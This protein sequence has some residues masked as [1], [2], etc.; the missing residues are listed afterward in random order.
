MKIFHQLTVVTALACCCC[1]ESITRGPYLQLSTPTSIVIRWRTDAVADSCVAYGTNATLLDL[2]NQNATLVTDHELT[3]TNLLPDTVYYYSAGSTSGAVAGTGT[4]F[5]FTTHPPPGAPQPIRVWVIGDAGTG[6]ANQIAVRDAFAAFNGTNRIHAWLQLGDNAYNSGTDAEYQANMFNLYSNLL[7]NTVTW[8]ALG[9][10]DTAQLTDFGG[11]YPYFDIFTLP[12]AGE[13]GGAASGTEHYYSFDVGMTHFICLDSMTASRATNGAMAAWLRTDL[14]ANTNRWTIAYWH[15]PPYSK[16]THDSDNI[17]EPEMV[18]MRQN[19]NP[20]LEAGGV[21]LV[22]SGHSHSYER[23]YLI[24]GHYGPSWTF[25]NTMVVQPGSGC[26]T[27]GAGAY[28]KPKHG[29]FP[30]P[31]SRGAV[32]GVVGTSGQL[33]GG[34]LNHPAMFVS[35]ST[36]GS[37]V[38]DIATNRLEAVFLSETGATNDWFSIRKDHFA[39]VAS[40]AVVHIA[41]DATTNLVVTGNDPDGAP[42]TF[43]ITALPTNGLAVNFNPAAGTLDYTPSHGSTNSD[44]LIFFATN[45]QFASAPGELTINI[46]PPLDA[47][48]NG[49]PDSWETLFGITDAA[50]DDD[51]DGAMNWQEYRAG[52]NPTNAFSWLH[53]TQIGPEGA[54]YQVVWSSVGGTR[55]RIEFSD[56]ATNGSFTGAFTS[57][58]RPAAAEM[59]PNP[60]GTPGTMSFTD[61]F[62]LTGGTPAR[63][64]RFYRVRIVP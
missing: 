27:N 47:N 52:T 21:D 25:T 50:A 33:G 45:R 22:L 48:T 11:A 39:P 46:V 57:L 5:S 26:E 54:G 59:D 58:P 31:G 44:A 2:T 3:L 62:T 10:H 19:F 28:L 6:T 55:Y 37:L 4:D 29:A 9:N 16:G 34:T 7:R 1:A 12:T 56:S 38:L 30:P 14:A 23:S 41:A 64:T 13:A 17:Y 24:N 49:I 63:G 18:E 42:L 53:F 35:L 32:Y 40:N 61:D 43:A 20:I 15:H 60:I 51:G 36:P 8:P